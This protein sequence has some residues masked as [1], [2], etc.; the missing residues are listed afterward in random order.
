VAE[1]ISFEDVA[2]AR[3][4]SAERETVAACVAIVE[5]NL[6]LALRLFSSG[7]AAER[8]VRA[9]QIRQLGEILEYM[10]ADQAR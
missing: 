5:A 10:S 9:R 8:P 1:I 4:R 7:P 6:H 2:R 3:R